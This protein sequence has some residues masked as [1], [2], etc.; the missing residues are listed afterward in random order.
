MSETSLLWAVLQTLF[1]LMGYG[2]ILML[3]VKATIKP[4]TCE[5]TFHNLVALAQL[6]RE[7]A[8]IRTRV[9]I[10]KSNLF[11]SRYSQHLL[12]SVFPSVGPTVCLPVHP[13]VRTSISPSVRSSVYSSVRPFVRLFVR[14]SVLP[15]LYLSVCS[16]V[17][18]LVYQ[19]A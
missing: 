15:S 7:A 9:F 1:S 11:R 14:P 18:L 19:Y 3:I 8:R 4:D 6:Y 5:N 12:L 17:R 2:G 13:S 10:T 16:S